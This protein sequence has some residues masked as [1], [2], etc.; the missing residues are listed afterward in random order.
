[1]QAIGSL[2]FIS[3]N[4]SREGYCRSSV[5][6]YRFPLTG[7]GGVPALARVHALPRADRPAGHG[8]VRDHL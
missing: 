8:S 3:L 1:M 5:I 7:Q 6:D 4:V 2:L